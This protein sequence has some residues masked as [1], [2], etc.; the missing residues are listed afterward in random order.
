MDHTNQAIGIQGAKGTANPGQ[1]GQIGLTPQQ[2]PSS[3]GGIEIE[4]I[5]AGD[6]WLGPLTKVG[7]IEI[8][9]RQN[10]DCLKASVAHQRPVQA[11]IGDVLTKG[12]NGQRAR[13]SRGINRQS[14][15]WR[16]RLRP[17]EL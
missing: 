11:Q 6:G 4:Q 7:G 1:L 17:R 5:V 15:G 16:N 10:L 14:T 3:A 13:S 2:N 9:G 12:L 8:L